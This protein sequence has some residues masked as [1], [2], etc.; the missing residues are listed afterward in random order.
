MFAHSSSIIE[1]SFKRGGGLKKITLYVYIYIYIFNPVGN[2][3][4]EVACSV[5]AVR[6]LGYQNCLVGVSGKQSLKPVLF[7]F[8]V[9]FIKSSCYI[10]GVRAV[11][12]LTDVCNSLSSEFLSRSRAHSSHYSG[13]VVYQFIIIH[14][15]A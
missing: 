6:V 10:L 2:V 3:H 12:Q 1:I 4:T 11:R 15:A 13:L 7:E 9:K 8:T 5:L 14:I